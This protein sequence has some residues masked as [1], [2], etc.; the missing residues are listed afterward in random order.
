MIIQARNLRKQFRV[1]AR[2]AGVTGALRGMVMH[3]PR[4]KSRFDFRLLSST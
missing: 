3:G 4:R 2:S 1:R